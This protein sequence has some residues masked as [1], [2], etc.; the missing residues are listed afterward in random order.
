MEIYNYNKEFCHSNGQFFIIGKDFFPQNH[1]F[2]QTTNEFHNS[3]QNSHGIGQK[4][5]VFFQHLWWYFFVSVL[6]IISIRPNRPYDYYSEQ[7]TAPIIESEEGQP[8]NLHEINNFF[9][10][11]KYYIEWH[12]YVIQRGDT[13]WD[14]AKESMG[15]GLAY[16]AIAERNQ[17]SNP[18]L[19]YPNQELSI[20]FLYP[21]N[22]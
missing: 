8:V 21:I 16:H 11:D 1:E 3:K 4:S 14:I 22:E 15:N 19:I 18:H 6:L 7:N 5:G 10:A 20:P 17:L 13:L 12:P 2:F 9:D